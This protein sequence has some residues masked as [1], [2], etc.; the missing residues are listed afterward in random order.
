MSTTNTIK[1]WRSAATGG[2]V[3]QTDLAVETVA[4]VI[5]GDSAV[6]GSALAI[7]T[8][9][10][11][12]V[13]DLVYVSGWNETLGLPA[14]TKADN[15]ASGRQAQ[16][17][18]RTAIAAGANGLVFTAFR[19]AANLNVGGTVGD[20]VYLD[21]T[22]GG[23]TLTPPTGATAVAQIV[24]RVAVV[25]GTVGVIVFDLRDFPTITEN[26]IQPL[27]ITNASI[28]TAAAIAY[29]KLAALASARLLV[30][31]VGNVATAVDVTG[32]VTISNAGVTAIGATKVT[33]AM[34][35]SGAGVGAL[36]TAG[37]GG[38]TSV[39]KTSAA[40]TTVITAHGSK[41]RACLVL[42]V[43]DETYAIGTGTL[44]TVKIGEADTLEK[45]MA[46]T[47]LDTEAAGTVL[48]FAFT[49]TA[50]KAVLVT[51]TAAIGNSTGGCSITVLAIPTT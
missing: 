48:A 36:L 15:D 42:V 30:G 10:A 38:S 51:T 33:N 12:S 25:S 8:S 49:N 2:V 21:A 45:A 34:L 43:V 37:L 27:A 1:A 7:Y 26:D 16:F 31:S 32:D 29:S 14:V 23:W 5:V 11:L 19:S 39:L 6:G 3:K 44:P 50:T 18:V 41:D 22:A 35:A 20:P 28:A 47:V 46:A 40:T 4:G 9:G 17:I 24:G 13:L